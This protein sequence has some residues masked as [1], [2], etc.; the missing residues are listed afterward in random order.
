MQALVNSCVRVLL[1]VNRTLLVLIILIA[2]FRLLI[3]HWNSQKLKIGNTEQL[4]M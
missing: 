3:A 2:N 1:L 4:E